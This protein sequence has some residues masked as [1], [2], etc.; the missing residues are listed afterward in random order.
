MTDPIFQARDL[1]GDQAGY[2]ILHVPAELFEK[3]VE[4]ATQA[5]TE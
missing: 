5:A 1:L 3:I 2:D 4:L